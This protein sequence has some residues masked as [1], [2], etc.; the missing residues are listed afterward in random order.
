MIVAAEAVRR[1]PVTGLPMAEMSTQVPAAA[2]SAPA[3]PMMEALAGPMMMKVVVAEVMKAV[4]EKVVAAE[5][6]VT[7]ARSEA[8]PE[9]MATETTAD[10][11]RDGVDVSHCQRE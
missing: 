6:A 10:S 3:A 5:E 11:L 7:E 1:V 4:P 8:G 2:A 9:T